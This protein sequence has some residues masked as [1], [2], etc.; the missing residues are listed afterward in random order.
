[1]SYIKGEHYN[2][3]N[4]IV[5]SKIERRKKR[6]IKEWESLADERKKLL[7]CS[8]FKVLYPMQMQPEANID[9][10]GRS[11]RD[12][13]KTI[14]ELLTNTSEETI[15]VVKPN[16]KSKYELTDSLLNLIRENKRIIPVNHCVTMDYVLPRINLVVT[17]TGTIAIECILGNIPVVTLT[18]TINNNSGN[19]LFKSDLSDISQMIMDVR[20]G[21]FPTNSVEEKIAFLNMLNKTSY[22]GMPYETYLD[23]EN[24]SACLNAFED[25]L[26]KQLGFQNS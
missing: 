25:V 24:L 9:V 6:I 15:I 11:H 23:P 12:Q 8:N 7:E 10:W 22:K 3:P 13:E 16:P 2:T 26:S 17:V 20:N 4:P 14:E 21:R 5:K 19:C 18:K 1:L